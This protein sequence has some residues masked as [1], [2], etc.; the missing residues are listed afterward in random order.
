MAEENSNIQN[1]KEVIAREAKR[2][3]AL[4]TPLP[5]FSMPII[6]TNL[7]KPSGREFLEELYRKVLLRDPEPKEME[8]YLNALDGGKMSKEYILQSV[9][10]SDEGIEKAVE[11]NIIRAKEVYGDILLKFDGEMFVEKA[12]LWLLGRKPEPEAVVDNVDRMKC[13]V[14]KADILRSIGGS[15]ECN[16]RGTRLVGLDEPQEAETQTSSTPG[17]IQKLKRA[18]IKVKRKIIG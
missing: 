11:I 5:E 9:A 2:L 12:Y 18:A 8:Q 3:K 10:L 13:G 16:N 6:Y 15:I 4:N 17:L 1:I 14:S 7:L